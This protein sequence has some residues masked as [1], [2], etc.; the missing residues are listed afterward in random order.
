MHFIIMLFLNVYVHILAY[1]FLLHFEV[2]VNIL[3]YLIFAIVS[4]LV[5]VQYCISCSIAV[6]GLVSS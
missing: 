1:I 5:S 6:L 4:M 2:S 3:P